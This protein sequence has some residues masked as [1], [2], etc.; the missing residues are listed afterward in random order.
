MAGVKTVN[1][2]KARKISRKKT[3][4][5]IQECRKENGR[6]NVEEPKN[7]CDQRFKGLLGQEALRR[8]LRESVYPA[9]IGHLTI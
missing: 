3:M 9:Y 2:T 4:T 1:D 7:E 5:S 6:S 8:G